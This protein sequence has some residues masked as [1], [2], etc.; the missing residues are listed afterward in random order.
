MGAAVPDSVPCPCQSLRDHT[1]CVWP[2]L[3]GIPH[4]PQ[5]QGSTTLWELTLAL[6]AMGKSKGQGKG[7]KG[8]FFA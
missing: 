1:I 3:L 7:K 2:L 6:E 5:L 8:Q 4:S